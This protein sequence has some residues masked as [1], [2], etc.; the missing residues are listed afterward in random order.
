MNL[1]QEFEAGHPR[2]IDVGK[3]QYQVHIT[4]TR[5]AYQSLGRGIGKLHNEQACSYLA[6][7]LLPKQI[8]DVE[9]VIDHKDKDAHWF[10]PIAAS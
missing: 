1:W 3:Q 10:A 4:G 9:L 6:T 5:N 7:K 2:H 8:C